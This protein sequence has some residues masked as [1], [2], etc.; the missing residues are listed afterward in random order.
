[1]MESKL[2]ILS[3]SILLFLLISC[4]PEKKKDKDAIL[5]YKV[6]EHLSKKQTSYLLIS[7]ADIQDSNKKNAELSEKGFEQAA[8]WG[9]YFSD[10]EIDLF[11]TSTETYAFQT[12]IPIVHPYKG[13]VR[14]I[15]NDFKFNQDFWS[16]TY[17]QKSIIVSSD[18]Q[19][20]DFVN[21]ILQYNKYKIKDI[22]N[23][24]YLIKVNI[25]QKRKIKDTLIQF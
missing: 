9:N 17:G 3:I 7:H 11:Y 21:D 23:E 8:F 14:N 19:N 5:K 1:M 13:Q 4:Q 15:E 18:Q 6:P 16:K 24:S 2:N 10:K 22:E 25:D 20:V 12:M